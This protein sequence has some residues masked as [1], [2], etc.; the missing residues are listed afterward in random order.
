M[1]TKLPAES[2]IKHCQIDPTVFE[3]HRLAMIKGNAAIMDCCNRF[4]AAIEILEKVNATVFGGNLEELRMRIFLDPMDR[5]QID[6]CQLGLGDDEIALIEILREIPITKFF[7]PRNRA[8]CHIR[9]RFDIFEKIMSP[10]D[11]MAVHAVV[12]IEAEIRAGY[13]Y[14]VHRYARKFSSRCSA[15]VD[16]DDLVQVGFIGLT[17]AIYGYNGKVKFITY[18]SWVILRHMIRAL[19]AS[20]DF[21]KL[22]SRNAPL[23]AAYYKTV[24]SEQADISFENVVEKTRI[25]DVKTGDY[26]QLTEKEIDILRNIMKKFLR[27]EDFQNDDGDGGIEILADPMNNGIDIDKINFDDLI[28]RANLTEPEKEIVFLAQ[29]GQKGFRSKWAKTHH[30]SRMMATNTLRR[31]YQKIENARLKKIR[32]TI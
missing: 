31:A 24:I 28:E 6:P 2:P 20:N 22:A 10:V 5:T 14:L 7:K 25:K 13:S 29:Y 19:S 4:K 26:R 18:A 8:Y 21:S 17:E 3:N 12:A 1:F 16:V 30:L 23:L 32:S 27:D 15:V 11:L 9:L